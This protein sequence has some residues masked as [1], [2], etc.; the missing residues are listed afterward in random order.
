VGRSV[1]VEVVD[2]KEVDV[3]G[4]HPG[5]T[6]WRSGS[7]CKPWDCPQCVEV[8]AGSWVVFLDEAR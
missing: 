4:L 2:S 3:D 1:S 5:P 8:A 7:Y 6:V